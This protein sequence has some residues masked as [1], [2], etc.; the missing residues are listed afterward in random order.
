MI[1]VRI[2][3]NRIFGRS[4]RKIEEEGGRGREKREGEGREGKGKKATSQYL[5]VKRKRFFFS[6][7]NGFIDVYLFI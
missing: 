4:G 7:Q 5:T 3:M 2:Q 6:F 1:A